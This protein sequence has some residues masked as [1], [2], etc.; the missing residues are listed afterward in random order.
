MNAIIIRNIC[1]PIFLILGVLYTSGC[2]KEVLSDHDEEDKDNLPGISLPADLLEQGYE[3]TWSDE[4]DGTTLDDEVWS[5]YFRGK[6]RDFVH[7]SDNFGY[8]A[9]MVSVSNGNLIIKSKTEEG[10]ARERT[11]PRKSGSVSSANKFHFA[12][13]YLEARI[14]FGGSSLNAGYR[15]AFWLDG[16]G[17][18]D[19]RPIHSTDFPK[20]NMPGWAHEVDILEAYTSSNESVIHK[21]DGDGVWGNVGKLEYGK[22]IAKLNNGKDPYHTIGLLWTTDGFTTYFD[23]VK[24]N[25]PVIG[26]PSPSEKYIMFSAAAH[27]IP[28]ESNGEVDMLVDYVRLYESPNNTGPNNKW[29]EIDRGAWVAKASSTDIANGQPTLGYWPARTIKVHGI[30]SRWFWRSEEAQN[31]SAK[32]WFKVDMGYE[33]SFKQLRIITPGY[34]SNPNEADT[35]GQFASSYEIYLSNEESAWN[36][37]FIDDWGTMIASGTGAPITD[38][39]FDTPQSGRYI[40]IRQTGT[41]SKKWSIRDIYAFKEK[42]YSGYTCDDIE[43]P[44]PLA[45]YSFDANA[46]SDIGSY[47][48]TLVGDAAA[49]FSDATRGKVLSLDGT[50]DYVDLPYIVNPDTAFTASVWVKRANTSNNKMILQ[51]EGSNGRPFFHWKGND[52][53]GSWLGQT[54]TFGPAEIND[55]DWHHLALVHDGSGSVTIY[56]DGVAGA[57]NTGLSVKSETGELLLGVNKTKNGMFFNGLIDNL[58]IY[59]SALSQNQ[60]TVLASE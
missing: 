50:G 25:D 60:I 7:P 23:G 53:I 11:V 38:E 39:C 56:V 29:T 43:V 33:Q 51:Q 28:V 59:D 6:K 55:T 18:A 10:T 21:T 49:G 35:E 36:S 42:A 4:F 16:L 14:K 19:N 37:S 22:G 5:P 24:V 9:D 44:T 47:N 40:T 15:P 12:Y 58:K 8:F 20:A 31:P 17:D 30:G 52:K 34:T 26:N 54:D 27:Y 46:D 48:G 2:Q 1:I 3:L 41:S 57:T 13:G 45:Q 32:Q